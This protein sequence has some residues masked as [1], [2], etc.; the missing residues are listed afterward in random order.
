MAG[1]FC[2]GVAV[3]G[4]RAAYDDVPGWQVRVPLTYK[5][6]SIIVVLRIQS[7]PIGNRNQSSCCIQSAASCMYLLPNQQEEGKV[8]YGW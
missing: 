5:Y 4:F 2:A 8:G 6:K 7:S 1:A 3:Y